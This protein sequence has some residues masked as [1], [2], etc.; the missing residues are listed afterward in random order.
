MIK[1]LVGSAA[2]AVSMLAPIAQANDTALPFVD[3]ADSVEFN[4]WNQL[5]GSVVTGAQLAAGYG[6]NVAGSGDAVL[7]RIAGTAYPAGGGLY[8]WSSP[9]S[10][11]TLT[12]ATVADN[13]TSVVFQSHSA[14]GGTG[15]GLYDVSLSYTVDGVDYLAALV[16]GNA[17]ASAYKYFSWDLSDVTGIDAIK[18]TFSTEAHANSF[19]FQLDQVVAAVPE[20]SEYALLLAGL[21]FVGFA[22]RRKQQA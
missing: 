22:A 16:D 7:T 20:P 12:D 17:Q 3:V 11:F 6:A 14:P 19:A 18:V 15:K 13:L 4:G 21:A 8:E 5:V 1:Y 10:T 2:L 9:F